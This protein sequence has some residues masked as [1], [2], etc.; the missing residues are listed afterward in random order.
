[1]GE[2]VCQQVWVG[3]SMGVL[4]QQ[5]TSPICSMTL[6][7]RLEF[8]IEIDVGQIIRFVDLEYT[9]SFDREGT[10]TDHEVEGVLPKDRIQ[11]IERL[12]LGKPRRVSD[13]NFGRVRIAANGNKCC[14]RVL[15]VTEKNYSKGTKA[16]PIAEWEREGGL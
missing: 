13:M 15:I 9:T 14:R 8:H 2:R 3:S 5:I 4:E 10:S 1:M 16:N 6:R 12:N 11:V 7:P